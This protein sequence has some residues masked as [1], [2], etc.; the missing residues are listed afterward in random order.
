MPPSREYFEDVRDALA[1]FLPRELRSVSSRVSSRN[2]KIW[3]GDLDREHYEVQAIG[4]AR[5]RLEVGWHAE[6]R[7]SEKNDL[8]LAKLVAAEK[9]WRR[10]LGREVKCGTFVGEPGGS[11]RRVSEVWD[12]P[13]LWGPE[14]AIE[15]A[16]RLAEYMH[17][18]EPIRRTPVTRPN[19]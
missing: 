6:H 3:Y 18:L 12:G 17:A 13:N 16:A 11:W 19:S 2:L 10:A 14:A 8:A 15:A 1:R 5:P 4:R 7:S 9:T